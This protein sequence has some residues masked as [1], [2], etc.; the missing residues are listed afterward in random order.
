M[1]KD[2]LLVGQVQSMLMFSCLHRKLLSIR[3]SFWEIPGG[4]GRRWSHTTPK[5]IPLQLFNQNSRIISVLDG[6]LKNNVVQFRLLTQAEFGTQYPKHGSRRS[7]I[8]VSTWTK[9]RSLAS[10]LGHLRH[11]LASIPPLKREAMPR[12]LIIPQRHTFR[13]CMC[14]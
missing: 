2:V 6:K 9:I 14:C 5:H 1:L 10:Q 12:R 3:G 13:I 8:S 4:I 7:R 11:Y